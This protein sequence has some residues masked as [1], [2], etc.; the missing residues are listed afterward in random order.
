MPKQGVI[1]TRKDG[2]CSICY[3]SDENVGKKKCCHVLDNASIN[4][5]H[6]RGTNFIDISGQIDD[7]DTTISIKAT[8]KKI[9]SYMK[10]L[11]DGLSKKEKNDL[12]DMLRDM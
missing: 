9:K 2:G 10:S 6:E 11:S 12:L 3:A 5:R 4:V 1:R 8:E 7:E